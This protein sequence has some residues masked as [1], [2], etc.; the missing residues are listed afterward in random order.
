MGCF[1]RIYTEETETRTEKSLVLIDEALTRSAI[2]AFYSACN[3][4][5][6]GFLE[7]VYIGALVVE[8]ERRG[9]RLIRAKQPLP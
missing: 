2:G 3:K 9:H 6:Y 5:G 8:L 7:N 4:L 1:A